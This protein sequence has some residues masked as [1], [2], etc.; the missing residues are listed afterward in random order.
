MC[1]HL[2]VPTG[3]V[4]DADL[5]KE[6]ERW[7]QEPG[8]TEKLDS[9]GGKGDKCYIMEV[10]PTTVTWELVSGGPLQK[11]GGKRPQSFPSKFRKPPFNHHL[12]SSI[13]WGLTP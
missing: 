3:K 11:D 12:R 10:A 5:H 2:D 13:G 8:W 1:L 7:P 4:W 6:L 9:D